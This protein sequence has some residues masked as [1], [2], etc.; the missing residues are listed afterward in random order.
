MLEWDPSAGAGAM[1]LSLHDLG[2]EIVPGR[3]EFFFLMTS[4][5]T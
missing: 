2:L 3:G 5:S 1:F 4:P